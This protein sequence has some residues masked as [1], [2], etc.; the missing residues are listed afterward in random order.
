MTLNSAL[1]SCSHA[2]PATAVDAFLAAYTPTAPPDTVV[3]P[4]ATSAPAAPAPAP[5]PVLHLERPSHTTLHHEEAHC[6]VTNIIY[7][8]FTILPD[9]ATMESMDTTTI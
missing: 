6:D 5:A 2:P 4:L 3:V 7:V 8:L 9:F 1:N